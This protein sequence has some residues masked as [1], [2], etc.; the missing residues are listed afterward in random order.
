MFVTVYV[1]KNNIKPEENTTITYKEH[2]ECPIIITYQYN[3][4]HK[5][6][7]INILKYE[8]GDKSKLIKQM[9]IKSWNMIHRNVQR[10][11]KLNIYY[12]TLEI[13]QLLSMKYVLSTCPKKLTKKKENKISGVVYFT[14][15]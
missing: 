11:V 8:T 14:K 6:I 12:S 7:Y 2:K 4:S 15:C 5:C 3:V 1:L 13:W 10:R 9:P